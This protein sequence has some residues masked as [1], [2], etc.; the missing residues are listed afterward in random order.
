MKPFLTISLP[1]LLSYS[2]FEREVQQPEKDAREM[3]E[4]GEES[5]KVARKEMGGL[6]KAAAVHKVGWVRR[7]F[8]LALHLLP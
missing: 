2:E 1:G 3:L 7:P 5:V 4:M 8:T 6:K